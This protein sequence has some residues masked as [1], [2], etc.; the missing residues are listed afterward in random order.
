MRKGHRARDCR[1]VVLC[2]NCNGKHHTAM[3]VEKTKGADDVAA[4]NVSKTEVSLN[5]HVHTYIQKKKKF[6]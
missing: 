1:T 4:Q 2:K 5:T 3:C 6:I